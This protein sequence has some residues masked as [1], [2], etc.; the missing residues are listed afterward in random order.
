MK[1]TFILHFTLKGSVS[2]LIILLVFS[3]S[4]A[5]EVPSLTF[6]YLLAYSSF[7]GGNKVFTDAM[8]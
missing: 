1:I 7:A 5:L 3:L 2:S 4:E 8:T 6:K